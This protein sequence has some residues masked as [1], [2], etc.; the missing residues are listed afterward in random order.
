MEDCI[1]RP[2]HTFLSGWWQSFSVVRTWVGCGGLQGTSFG[3]PN[4]SEDELGALHGAM[5]GQLL[6]VQ[7][8]LNGNNSQGQQRMP[9]SP[10]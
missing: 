2:C 10:Y 8:A 3:Y 1:N 6:Q 4:N 9:S 7:G 5:T